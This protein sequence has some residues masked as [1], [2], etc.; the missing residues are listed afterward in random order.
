[1]A[2]A[3]FIKEVSEK[4]HLKRPI[5]ASTQ[6]ILP[7]CITKPNDNFNDMKIDTITNMLAPKIEE[8]RALNP[9]IFKKQFVF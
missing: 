4:N 5:F 6:G 7:Y 9:R 3:K 2:D 8:I 1:M